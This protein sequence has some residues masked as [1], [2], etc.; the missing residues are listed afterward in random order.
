MWVKVEEQVPTLLET[1]HCRTNTLTCTGQCPCYDGGADGQQCSREEEE[2]EG[3]MFGRHAFSDA[4]VAP[5][6]R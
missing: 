5:V 4:S 3:A 6:E 1:L 2:S